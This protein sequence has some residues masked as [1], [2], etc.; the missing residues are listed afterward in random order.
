MVGVFI[1]SVFP[2]PISV[3]GAKVCFDDSFQARD[4]RHRLS[5]EVLLSLASQRMWLRWADHFRLGVPDIETRHAWNRRDAKPGMN[6]LSFSARNVN[7][8]ARAIFESSKI[9]KELNEGVREN[10]RKRK[11]QAVESDMVVPW[12]TTVKRAQS[13]FDIYRIEYIR[14]QRA[15]GNTRKCNV[16]CKEY[17]DKI[18]ESF[19]NLPDPEKAELQERAE[20]TKHFSKRNRTLE[21]GA[22][23]LVL[24][25]STAAGA[26]SAAAAPAS[27][28]GAPAAAAGGP[29]AAA[30]AGAPAAAA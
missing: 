4:L 20:S 14:N 13:A 9:R 18:W 29:A 11:F 8:E 7:R 10:G 26:G 12:E 25:S 30:A 16:L 2:Y 23:G 22:V 6:W 1:L 28:A 15:I 27:A 19:N 24:V 21:K 3:G 5:R 17:R